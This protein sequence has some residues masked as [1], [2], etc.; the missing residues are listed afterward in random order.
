[1]L[2]A[3]GKSD[4][5]FSLI[6]FSLFLFSS[7]IRSNSI[8]LRTT[9]ISHMGRCMPTL[10]V[11]NLGAG[12][13]G[14]AR[15][16]QNLCSYLLLFWGPV[17]NFTNRCLSGL[18]LF[19]ELP[20]FYFLCGAGSWFFFSFPKS[21]EGAGFYGRR[22]RAGDGAGGVSRRAGGGAGRRAGKRG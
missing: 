14:G 16:N 18:L 4:R 1:M 8:G 7:Q 17:H 6:F 19:L 12:D 20:V 3:R 21:A 11:G 22:V 13:L 2:K 9:D 5:M 10:G 15:G